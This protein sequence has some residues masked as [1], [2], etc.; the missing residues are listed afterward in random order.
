MNMFNKIPEFLINTSYKKVLFFKIPCIFWD[1]R[2]N[3]SDAI[4]LLQDN[5]FYNYLR[6]LQRIFLTVLQATISVFTLKLAV[7]R[8]ICKT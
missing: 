5:H 8:K 6:N 1:F 2:I 7:Q 3:T 4:F